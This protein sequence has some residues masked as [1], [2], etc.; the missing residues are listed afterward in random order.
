[1]L[2]LTISLFSSESKYLE[3]MN[4]LQDYM[5]SKKLPLTMQNRVISY[6]DYRYHNSYFREQAVFSVMPGKYPSAPFSSI[7]IIISDHIKQELNLYCSKK[8]IQ[9]VDVFK[10]LPIYVLR[11]IISNLKQ[12]VFMPNDIIVKAGTAGDCMYFLRKG[13]VAVYTA[14]GKEVRLLT[15]IFSKEAKWI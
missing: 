11:D 13:T 3:V 4:Q 6:Y 9:R 14:N 5:R 8:I 15:K 10:E 2:Q 7:K 1:M 12:E